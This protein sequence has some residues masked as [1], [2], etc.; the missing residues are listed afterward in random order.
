[1]PAYSAETARAVGIATEYL[2]CDYTRAEK[3][4]LMKGLLQYGIDLWGIVRACSASRG[5]QAHGGHGS[6]RKW[7]MMFA[8]LMFG[9]TAM[10]KPTVTYPA[11]RIGEDMQTGR[12]WCWATGDTNY[13]YTGHQGL[14]NG[15]PVSTTPGW[16]PYEHLP[17]AQWY[18]CESGYTT[19]L[20]EAYRR[21]C[22][23]HS[24]IAEALCA[25]IMNATGM[26]NHPEFFGYC[27]RWMTDTRNDSLEITAIKAARGWDF[28]ANWQ[29]HG[30]CWDAVTN[31][32]WKAYRNSAAIH[33]PKKTSGAKRTAGAASIVRYRG[34]AVLKIDHTRMPVCDVSAYGING[35]LLFSRSG[36]TASDGGLRLDGFPPGACVVEVKNREGRNTESLFLIR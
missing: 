28:S 5:W 10:A 33:D 18:C 19:P 26:W 6:G 2:V 15:Q 27:D 20:G 24:W 3:D 21:C 14:W 23:S 32:M 17:P 29:R 7:P 12:G 25:R 13:V 31:E 1:M 16:G 8:G 35:G 34:T 30:A 36:V 11:L 9:D 4:S 22:T